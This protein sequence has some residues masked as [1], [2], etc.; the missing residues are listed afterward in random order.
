MAEAQERTEEPS[1]KRKED[2]RKRGQIAKSPDLTF[3]LSFLAGLWL[4][5]VFLPGMNAELTLYWK[6]A[7]AGIARP[8][9]AHQQAMYAAGRAFLAILLP[10]FAALAA[11]AVV[12]NAIP[13]GIPRVELKFD[14]NRLNPAEGIKRLW[15]PDSVVE[16]GKSFLKLAVVTWLVW[17][18]FNSR[19]DEIAALAVVGPAQIAVGTLKLLSGLAWKTALAGLVFGA[20]DLGYRI[21]QHRKRIKM[22]KEE[23]KEERKSMDGNPL[24]KGRIRQLM[25][26][27]SG[28]KRLAGVPKADVVIV[29]PTHYAVALRYD[30]AKRGA[31]EVVA[32]GLDLMALKIIEIAKA[33]GVPVHRNPPLARSLYRLAEPGD[34]IP[35]ALYKA[36]AEVFAWVYAESRRKKRGGR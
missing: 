2:F 7:I 34:C 20:A 3:A 32:K 15:R 4:L 6:E 26:R 14:L 29:N 36:V 17:G 16:L 35:P 10:F 9:G 30:R 24:V 22:T 27:Y 12:F 18:E 11:A 8:D 21:W 31:P 28:R 1:G 23:V 5:G 13:S 19:A 25:R 33:S